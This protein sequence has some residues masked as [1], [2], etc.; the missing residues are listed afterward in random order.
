[1]QVHSSRNTSPWWSHLQII[2]ARLPWRPLFLQHVSWRC[3]NPPDILSSI[4]EIL[5]FN[6]VFHDGVTPVS[7]S[8]LKPMLR[9]HWVL[10]SPYHRA[11]CRSVY[12]LCMSEPT[13]WTFIL[14]CEP[15]LTRFQILTLVSLRYFKAEC[16]ELE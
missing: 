3:C 10:A 13:P 5:L 8:T 12:T 16:E 15:C 6:L 7:V 14:K 9:F 11:H 4:V 2:Q 1:M